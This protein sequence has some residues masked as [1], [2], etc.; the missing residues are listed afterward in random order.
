MIGSLFLLISWATFALLSW[1]KYRKEAR[2]LALGS[3]GGTGALTL[4][5][6][7]LIRSSALF[8]LLDGALL[9]SVAYFIWQDLQEESK[10]QAHA[11]DEERVGRNRVRSVIRLTRD[12]TDTIDREKNRRLKAVGFNVT[13]RLRSQVVAARDFLLAQEPTDEVAVF[14]ERETD[15]MLSVLRETLYSVTA[16][17][18]KVRMPWVSLG[19]A[20]CPHNERSSIVNITAISSMGSASH[21]P[22]SPVAVGMLRA[23]ISGRRPTEPDSGPDAHH[24]RPR[25]PRQGS[26]PGK[27][28]SELPRSLLSSHTACTFSQFPPWRIPNDT[29]AAPKQPQRLRRLT[30][31][32]CAL[33]R[34]N[35][36]GATHPCWP[37]R[38]TSSV[39]PYRGREGSELAV[40]ALVVGDQSQSRGSRRQ[41][42][43]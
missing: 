16:Q 17:V 2:T 42:H 41:R 31:R 18:E 38:G 12:T 9:G 40:A 14:S 23:R 1:V 33:C 5:A 29:Q 30:A 22:T 37:R 28:S 19:T 3:I 20:A 27:S 8:A 7:L 11:S 21:E 39:T 34:S 15:R 24:S 10:R 6:L 26:G 4:L 43:D 36:R 32:A 35:G 13:E 25:A